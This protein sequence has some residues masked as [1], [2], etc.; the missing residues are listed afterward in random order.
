MMPPVTPHEIKC[1]VIQSL[2]LEDLT[3]E[4]IGDAQP[5]FQGGLGLDSIDALE[6]S[7]ALR[8]RYGVEIGEAGPFQ[9]RLDTAANLAAWVNQRR[10][11]LLC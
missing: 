8:A 9:G 5:L 6:L 7:I 11:G 4:A 1:L 3:P 10:E 2:G